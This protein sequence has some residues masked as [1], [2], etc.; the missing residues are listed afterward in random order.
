[1]CIPLKH[2]C[3]CRWLTYL[4]E[5]ASL[6]AKINT[7]VFY[8]YNCFP[9]SF[10]TNQSKS[11]IGSS[12]SQVFNMIMRSLTIFWVTVRRRAI[13]KTR[14]RAK[15]NRKRSPHRLIKSYWHFFLKAKFTIGDKIST[16]T[17][18]KFDT[19][20]SRSPPLPPSGK[21]HCVFSYYL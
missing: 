20:S 4:Q 2:R 9:A 17:G 21:W 7:P 5:W 16:W 13:H 14:E 18:Y 8:F 12:D 6:Q 15:T 10:S 3:V 1:M 11:R 19:I